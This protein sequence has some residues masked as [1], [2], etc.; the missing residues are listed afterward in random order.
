MERANYVFKVDNSAE[1]KLAS[2]TNLGQ[3][4][5]AT[6]LE[7]M[8]ASIAYLKECNEIRKQEGLPELKVSAWLMAV[9]QVNANHAKYNIE[10]AG[11]YV[12][13]ENLAWGYG[14]ANTAA[15]PYRGWYD[16]EKAEY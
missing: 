3:V 8:Q 2:Y 14:D 15:S 5:D 6:S 7:N 9:A 12:T 1:G 4:D 11:V 10:H 13:G 16:E